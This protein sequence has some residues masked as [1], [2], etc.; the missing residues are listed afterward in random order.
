MAHITNFTD[1]INALPKQEMDIIEDLE[2]PVSPPASTPT[3]EPPIIMD[4][5]STPNGITSISSGE[6]ILPKRSQIADLLKNGPLSAAICGDSMQKGDVALSRSCGN[7]LAVHSAPYSTPNSVPQYVQSLIAPSFGNLIRNRIPSPQPKSGRFPAALV[8]IAEQP[9]ENRVRF[10]FPIEGRSAGSIAGVSSTAENKTFPTI[11]I[12]GYKGPAKVVVSCVEDKFYT[13]LNGYKTYRAHPHNL[14]GKHCK[15]GVCIMDVNEET[16]TCQ[17]S[18]IGVQCVTKRQIEASLQIRKRI[19]VDPF[20]LGF[21]H[22]NSDRTTVRLCFQV[23]LKPKEGGL[24]PLL[25]V[26]SSLI[27]DKRAHPDLNI[28][29]LSDDNSPVEGG[30]KIL[31]FCSK[32]K[33]EDI[34]VLFLHYGK[35]DEEILTTKGEFNEV[36]VHDQS[37]ISFKTPPYPDLEIREPVKVSICLRQPSKKVQ[38]EPQ[39]FWYLPNSSK[40]QARN[41]SLDN[42]LKRKILMIQRIAEEVKMTDFDIKK[43][44]HNIVSNDTKD[45][46][47]QPSPIS[48]QIPNIPSA[49]TLGKQSQTIPEKLR[50][51]QKSQGASKS[52]PIE[53][54]SQVKSR[55]PLTGSYG[56]IINISSTSMDNEKRPQLQKDDSGF[57]EPSSRNIIL[58]PNETENLNRNERPN[59]N[60]FF[61]QQQHQQQEQQHLANC[62]R[63][64][65]ADMEEFEKEPVSTSNPKPP[66]NSLPFVSLNSHISMIPNQEV[67]IGTCADDNFGLRLNPI[68]FPTQPLDLSTLSNS[69]VVSP[70]TIPTS[71]TTQGKKQENSPVKVKRKRVRK[72]TEPLPM[73]TM[74]LMPMTPMPHTTKYDD[75]DEEP[76]PCTDSGMGSIVSIRGVNEKALAAPKKR[77]RTSK[78]KQKDSHSQMVG[79][80]NSE[81]ERQKLS[82]PPP[83]TPIVSGSS[84]INGLS[85]PIFSSIST[86]NTHQNIEIGAWGI[87]KETADHDSDRDLGLVIDTDGEED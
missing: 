10:R 70:M 9:A 73:N 64:I 23:F 63:L 87:K 27:K 72:Q 15:E 45:K 41:V 33:K 69:V 32:I 18:N 8:K 5:F 76:N 21:E 26:V 85:M 62:V 20:G 22:K 35:N 16:M 59:M 68:K 60:N 3:S 83:L 29:D 43:E 53:K 12:V 13:E 71:G 31:L 17:F 1:M 50:N 79:S 82:S 42:D 6:I 84:P 80:P 2:S 11:E 28:V 54:T 77:K 24:V 44:E 58:K 38:S 39:D 14:V 75:M 30:K 57:M 4:R 52:A 78:P 34:E 66:S 61:Q 46:F 36:N 65:A 86:S 81:N 37:G 56:G 47:I 7:H 19:Q 67:F 51:I 49:D 25:P 48:R 40:I 55:F 74:N